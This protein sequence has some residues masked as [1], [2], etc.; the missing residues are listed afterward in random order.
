MC[1]LIGYKIGCKI[2]LLLRCMIMQQI[3]VDIYKGSSAEK[4]PT[5]TTLS[6][7]L[8]IR[9]KAS[10]SGWAS[11]A[12]QPLARFPWH[13][14]DNEFLHE[15]ASKISADNPNSTTSCYENAIFLLIILL[16]NYSM[17]YRAISISCSLVTSHE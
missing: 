9:C 10:L 5:Q 12:A 1:L 13:R 2:Y 8:P 11:C 6:P 14:L 17:S 7:M 15:S 3:V 16:M 4:S